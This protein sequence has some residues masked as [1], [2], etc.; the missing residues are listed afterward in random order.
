MAAWTG[1]QGHADG[2]TAV[3]VA[4]NL[5]WTTPLLDRGPPRRARPRLNQTGRRGRSAVRGTRERRS[6]QKKAGAFYQEPLRKLKQ[7]ARTQRLPSRRSTRVRSSE[8][9]APGRTAWTRCWSAPHGRCCFL[10]GKRAAGFTPPV[11]RAAATVPAPMHAARCP[12]VDLPTRTPVTL[13]RR[14]TAAQTPRHAVG[15]AHHRGADPVRGMDRRCAFDGC[16]VR[17]AADGQARSRCPPGI[18]GG[19]NAAPFRS[20][21]R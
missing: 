20:P 12:F 18:Q 1:R 7:Q 13:G 6:V 19:H 10:R 17:G 14:V 9:T 21:G 11:R 16:G 2:S 5:H 15:A 8:A 3:G 4:A